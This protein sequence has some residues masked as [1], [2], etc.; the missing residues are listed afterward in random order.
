M[1]QVGESMGSDVFERKVKKVVD[2]WSGMGLGW[3]ERANT[4]RLVRGRAEEVVSG[5]G[6]PLGYPDPR[7]FVERV[8]DD[9]L[10]PALASWIM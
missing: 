2:G 6:D 1:Q 4:E 5:M 7:R 9:F 10:G 8:M 3:D